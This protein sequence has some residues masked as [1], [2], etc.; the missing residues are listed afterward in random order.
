[1]TGCDRG[2]GK[3]IA[4]AL[5][6][7]GASVQVDCDYLCYSFGKIRLTWTSSRVQRL[8]CLLSFNLNV[9]DVVSTPPREQILV[10]NLRCVWK[11]WDSCC[12][13]GEKPRSR[14]YLS[15]VFLE[16]PQVAFGNR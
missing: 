12:N 2:I 14:S 11:T 15:Y 16:L 7:E 5:V 8:D 9:P 6:R 13:L 10:E 4:E 1:M 3:H